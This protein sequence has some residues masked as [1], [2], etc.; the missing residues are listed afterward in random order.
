MILGETDSLDLLGA[1]RV[2]TTA[3]EE[4][5]L[6]AARQDFQDERV[7]RRTWVTEA[8]LAKAGPNSLLLG[9]RLNCVTLGET[10]PFTRSVPRFMRTVA[11]GHVIYLDN[12]E[13]DVRA[14]PV[15]TADETEELI[16]LLTCKHRRMPV[17]GISLESVQDHFQL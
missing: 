4:Q 2:E 11:Q 7:A 6:W 15:E 9:F 13:V 5:K 8:M 12:V 10:V 14:T 16:Q 3:V 17:V 1:Q